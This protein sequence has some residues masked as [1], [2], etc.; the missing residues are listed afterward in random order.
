MIWKYTSGFEIR[1]NYNFCKEI[2][3]GNWIAAHSCSS[4]AII[5]SGPTLN[6]GFS[7]FWKQ[8]N[9][10]NKK[11]ITRQF[12]RRNLTNRLTNQLSRLQVIKTFIEL[13][14]Q[15]QNTSQYSG[16]KKVR[17][18]LKVSQVLVSTQ[19]RLCNANSIFIYLFHQSEWQN[20]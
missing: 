13:T 1:G 4:K 19:S 6:L 12:Q 7:V 3:K 14:S 15:A 20:L 2:S 18:I 9:C 5:L 10:F 11:L 8:F 17:L 16:A